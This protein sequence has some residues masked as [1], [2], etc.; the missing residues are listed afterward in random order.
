MVMKSGVNQ[1]LVGCFAIIGSVLFVYDLGV[2]AQIVASN[3]FKTMFL[4][5]S[6]DARSGTVFALFTGGCF[7]GAFGAG[8]SDRLGRRGIILMT[9]CIR[10]GRDNSDGGSRHCN[11]VRWK[12]DCWNWCQFFYGELTPNLENYLAT[13]I[14]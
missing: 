7:L 5:E 10:G 13:L 8:F 6:A 9:C 12:T 4:Q 2:I 11:F 14:R 1:F 3:S